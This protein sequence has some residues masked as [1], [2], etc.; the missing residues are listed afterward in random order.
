MAVEELKAVE[1]LQWAPSGRGLEGVLAEP[2]YFLTEIGGRPSGYGWGPGWS[3]T[4]Y[5]VH[6]DITLQPRDWLVRLSNGAVALEK[7][8]PLG[9]KPFDL[10][11]RKARIEAEWARLE[12]QDR[13]DD[14][15]YWGRD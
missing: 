12:A 8:R 13:E 7:E 5:T 9:A 11:E 4:F 2:L 14:E 1:A 15:Q 6:G 10:A 3:I